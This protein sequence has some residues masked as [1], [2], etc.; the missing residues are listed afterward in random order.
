MIFLGLFVVG[1]D[2]H[3]SI[4]IWD[5]VRDSVVTRLDGPPTVPL[6]RL[7]AARDQGGACGRRPDSIHLGYSLMAVADDGLS[8]I[9][10]TSS[11]EAWIWAQKTAP[12]RYGI[13][14]R[15]RAKRRRK[16]SLL[17][18]D[19]CWHSCLHV[20]VLITVDPRVS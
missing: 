1:A 17:L 5:T 7:Q 8:V 20:S 19:F 14:G 9:I 12:A 16:D 13:D 3:G 15:E 6:T 11:F 10:V 4:F 18:C 2:V